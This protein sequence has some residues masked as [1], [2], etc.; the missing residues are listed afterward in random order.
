MFVYTTAL[1]VYERPEGIKIA[2]LFIISM[3]ATSLLSRALR[4]TELRILAIELDQQA[5]EFI[6]E[7]AHQSRSHRG[8][9]AGERRRSGSGGA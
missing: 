8:A 7:N 5:K 2:S 6:A 1:N 4:S 9:Q 3:V